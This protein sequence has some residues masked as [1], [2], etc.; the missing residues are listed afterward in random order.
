MNCIR[1][2]NSVMRKLFDF[3][4]ITGAVFGSV[5]IAMNVPQSKYGYILF[6]ISSI[7]SMK[8]LIGTN[9]PKSILLINVFYVFVNAFG[10]YRWCIQ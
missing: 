2:Y 3:L 4:A 5:L 10:I 6:L 1:L 7:A 8:L 9:V